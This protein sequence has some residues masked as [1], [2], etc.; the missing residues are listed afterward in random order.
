MIEIRLLPALLFCSGAFSLFL[1]L[2]ALN[3]RR[4]ALAQIFALF[5]GGV[6]VY[7]FGYGL[8]LMGNTLG[9][10]LFWSKVQYVGIAFLPGFILSIAICYTEKQEFFTPLRVGLIFMIPLVTLGARL[11]NPYHHLF[12]RAAEMLASDHGALL[13]IEPGPL[14]LLHVFYSNATWL[15][16]FFLLLRFFF[17][18]ARPYRR[19]TLVIIIG[20]S[21][22]WVGY[23]IYLLGLGPAHIDLNPLLLTISLPVYAFGMFKLSLFSLIPVARDKV[24]EG[25]RDAVIV[26]DPE[27]RLVDFNR[28]CTQLFPLLNNRQIG[29]PISNLFSDYPDISQVFSG[30]RSPAGDRSPTGDRSMEI[31]M[32]VGDPEANSFFHLSFNSL[33]DK[34]GKEIG[35]IL[36]FTDITSQKKF[37]K[38]LEEMA[39]IDELTGLHNRR[40]LKA[41]SEIEMHRYQRNKKP[42][43]I[44]MLDLDHFKA[45]N[46]TWGHGGGD[47]VLRAFSTSVKQN[48]RAMDIFGRYGGEEFMILMPETAKEMAMETAQRI[49][50]LVENLAVPFEDNIISCTVSIGVSGTWAQENPDL[51][52]LI[53]DADKA[54]YAAKHQGRNQAVLGSF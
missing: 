37:V 9:E 19:Q 8:E 30:D 26:L 28:R 35:G 21:I 11:S 2:Y 51:E 20:S 1:A 16:S 6:A 47:T 43:A 15:L 48:I 39:T 10:M 54:L 23:V 38:E 44:L 52:S 31:E 33:L 12:Y 29:F 7:A 13:S 49:C 32:A 50:R 46:D 3:I 34:N 22:Q 4:T 17:R 53:Q 42:F 40:H 36:T 25:M 41:I 14:Y 24:F 45:I 27:S 18:A 5:A